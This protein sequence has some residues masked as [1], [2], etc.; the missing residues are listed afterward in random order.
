MSILGA[1]AHA[2]GISAFSGNRESSVAPTQVRV[3]T[4][5]GRPSLG[6]TRPPRLSTR[7]RATSEDYFGNNFGGLTA[8]VAPESPEAKWRS[9]DLSN[10]TL[11]RISIREL[12]RLLADVSP[13]VSSAL[14]HFILFGNAGYEMTAVN[15]NGEVDARGQAALSAFVNQL[16][17]QDGHS[18]FGTIINQLWAGA[19]MR[20]A[21]SAEIVLDESGRNPIDFVAVDPAIFRFKR[22]DAGARGK[23]WQLGQFVSG[24]WRRLDLPTVRYEPIHP[25]PG[26][27]PYGRSLIA[28]SI[29]VSLFLIGLLRDL[30]RVIAHQGYNR[31][32][33]SVNY[34]LLEELMPEAVRDDPEKREAWANKAIEEIRTYLE[35]LE[36]DDVYVHSDIIEVNRAAKDANVVGGTSGATNMIA[37]LERMAVRA[38]KTQPLLMGI[39]EATSETHAN[40]QWEIHA[41][42]IKS[43]Q[44]TC[45]NLLTRLFGLALRVQGIQATVQLKFSELRASEQMRDAQTESIILSNVEKKYNMGII[46]QEQAAAELGYDSA[47]QPAPRLI[48]VGDAPDIVNI[49]EE[50]ERAAM[51]RELREAV[52]EAGRELQQRAGYHVALLNGKH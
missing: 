34:E 35:K 37:A 7:A 18:E 46:S 17:D 19:F 14:Y 43:M 36:P 38:L 47:D 26:G 22:V 33:V 31:D 16:S 41:A 42:G 20:G 39:N 6:S 2:L 9:L 4:R 1:A 13:E 3:A 15:R 24:E 5:K 11:S 45:E 29:F 21:F 40:R 25:L 51:L 10:K 49:P 30:R 27:A 32:D 12:T 23:V 8:F 48:D 28:P 50:S 44:H 52:N